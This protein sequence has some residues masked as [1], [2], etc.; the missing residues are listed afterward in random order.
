[1]ADQDIE[2]QRNYNGRIER[3][4]EC[5]ICHSIIKTY[6]IH[7]KTCCHECS[8]KWQIE[9]TKKNP[10]CRNWRMRPENK[11]KVYAKRRAKNLF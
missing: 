5:V 11:E 9:L 7:K 8:E 4:V 3:T 1:M 10:K 6:Y 2:Y